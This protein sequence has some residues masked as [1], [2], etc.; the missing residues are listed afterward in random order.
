MTN[1]SQLTFCILTFDKTPWLKKSLMSIRR[2]CKI[3]YFVKILSQGRPDLE[4]TKFLEQLGDDKIELL[5]SEVNL[6]CDGGRKFLAQR[7]MTPF[8]MM[9]DDDMYLTETSVM[10]ALDV[11]QRD[12]EIGTVSMPQYSPQGRLI[13]PG[14]Q[15]LLVRDGVIHMYRPSV[16]TP[17][18][19]IE[20]QH[21][22]G[23]AMFFRT[24]MREVFTWDDRSGFLQ[25]LD[26]SLQI[27]RSA[28]WKQAIAPR[29]RLVHDR[30]WVGKK[31]NYE[32][33][34]FNGMTL[35]RNYEYFRK[36]WGLRLNLRTHFLYEA[37]FPLVTLT[38][39]PV[40]VSQIDKYTR[41]ARRLPV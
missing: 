12:S 30:S 7:V 24:E 22:D 33:T 23:G 8:A 38:R 4:L 28:R 21:I 14:G 35:H 2:Y 18:P 29:G 16:D 6:G 39:F 26:K 5:T 19:W 36:K 25:D 17:T 13:S 31:P 40:T 15:K 20:I 34:R 37:V 27:V 11:L 10:S 32:G 3:D 9:L 41:S 1:D